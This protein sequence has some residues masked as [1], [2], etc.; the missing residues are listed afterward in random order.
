MYFV[1]YDTKQKAISI[2]YMMNDFISTSP[3]RN[4]QVTKFSA[5]SQKN[6]LYIESTTEERFSTSQYSFDGKLKQSKAKML[7]VGRCCSREEAAGSSG[8]RRQKKC[9]AYHSIRF[10]K[11]KQSKAKMLFV[12]R[13]KS[14]RQQWK[15]TTQEM[16]SILFVL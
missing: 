2:Q 10:G 8:R 6:S 9:S 14:S 1:N 13:L 15:T 4:D 5:L 12:G 7:F 16:F 3:M 11:L